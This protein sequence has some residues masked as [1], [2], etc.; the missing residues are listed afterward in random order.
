[1][2]APYELKS[3]K[4]FVASSDKS[5]IDV[6]ELTRDTSTNASNVRI[7]EWKKVA[8]VLAASAGCR[9][10]SDD[11]AIKKGTAPPQS[12]DALKVFSREIKGQ[13]LRNLADD[14]VQSRLL[15]NREGFCFIDVTTSFVDPKFG[16]QYFRAQDLFAWSQYGVD[17]DDVTATT[18]NPCDMQAAGAVVLDY[19][20][21]AREKEERVYQLR[22]KEYREEEKRL[23]QAT[24][25]LEEY[26]KLNYWGAPPPSRL[27]LAAE[28]L[29]PAL[30]RRRRAS[31]LAIRVG[32]PSAASRFWSSGPPLDGK[33]GV[34][35]LV[36]VD[37][38]V[39]DQAFGTI[40]GETRDGRFDAGNWWYVRTTHPDGGATLIAYYEGSFA[41]AEVYNGYT[42]R[43]ELVPLP[44]AIDSNFRSDTRFYLACLSSLLLRIVVILI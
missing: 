25:E 7:S 11:D 15:I 43:R 5:K 6:Y 22:Y 9:P 4:Q 27:V 20:E 40:D 33:S 21:M 12:Y 23:E 26:Q 37:Q 36:V 8:T 34:N 19:G 38:E 3:P 32:S 30:Q 31:T 29:I 16:V 10:P 28:A 39:G 17:E 35:N 13:A 24:K 18:W 41:H 14:L 1:M 2:G 44:Y 42:G